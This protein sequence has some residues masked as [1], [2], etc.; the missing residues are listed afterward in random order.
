MPVEGNRK[1]ILQL[2]LNRK[3]FNEK[4]SLMIVKWTMI[5]P[6]SDHSLNSN[7]PPITAH[8]AVVHGYRA[9]NHSSLGS[10]SFT[11]WAVGGVIE[12]RLDEQLANWCSHLDILSH[13]ILDRFIKG[14]AVSP[15]SVLPR[16]HC[17][18]HFYCNWIIHNWIIFSI[19]ALSNML[20][21]PH[22]EICCSWIITQAGRLCD[23]PCRDP[24]DLGTHI[25]K[26]HM[27]GDD[28]DGHVCRWISCPRNGQAFKDRYRLINHLRTHTKEMPFKCDHSGCGKTFS[29]KVG[30]S[31]IIIWMLSFLLHASILLRILK[32]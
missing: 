6:A 27:T 32:Q 5:S 1:K 20:S 17:H 8:I 30:N 21:A 13:V 19:M 7:H 3:K 29:R 14:A 22:P 15:A 25:D 12:F 2:R 4:K 28:P 9:A 31:I 26:D 18:N 10:Q 23:K 11:V 16:S 24:S